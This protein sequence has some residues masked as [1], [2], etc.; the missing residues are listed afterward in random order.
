[1]VGQQHHLNE[2]FAICMNLAI[3]SVKEKFILM[4]VISELML[5]QKN[6]YG[7]LSERSLSGIKKQ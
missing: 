6:V 3:F 1:M 5:G 4:H 7:V 2:N